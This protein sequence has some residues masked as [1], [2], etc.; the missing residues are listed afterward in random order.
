MMSLDNRN[1]EWFNKTMLD[2]TDVF[3]IQL[4]VSKWKLDAEA[5]FLTLCSL[6]WNSQEFNKIWWF[7]TEFYNKECCDLYSMNYSDPYIHLLA[8]LIQTT[9]A[10]IKHQSVQLA[11]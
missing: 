2:I 10:K 8:S 6:S 9:A 4:H 3:T 1:L 7:T 11:C 5:E